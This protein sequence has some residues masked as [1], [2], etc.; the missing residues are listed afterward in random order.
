MF[1]PAQ[2]VCG[3]P[4]LDD[5]AQAHHRDPV[6]NLGCDIE[7]MGDEQHRQPQP[8]FQCLGQRQHLSLDR[9]VKRR[10]RFVGHQHIG[11]E[12]QRARNAD[13]LPLPAREFMREAL[14]RAR[15][16]ANQRQQFVGT[17]KCLCRRDAMGDRPV[18]D[19]PPNAAT[20]IERGEW[21]LEHHLDMLA[22]DPQTSPAGLGE[23]H[24]ADA[25]DARIG[26]G[27]PHHEPA[28][29]ALARA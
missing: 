25:D 16:E 4:D 24:F 26:V 20:R 18:G 6:A 5:F 14:R 22:S 23:I 29:R 10:H 17:R 27:E 2:Q 21:V 28:D 12:R 7:V 9:D 11:V 13:P 1:R 15:V 8:R 3:R 19:D